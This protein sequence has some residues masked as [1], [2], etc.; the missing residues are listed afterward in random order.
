MHK[1]NQ[2]KK[3]CTKFFHVK[4]QCTKKIREKNVHKIHP[5]KKNSVQNSSPKNILHKKKI[6]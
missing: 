6:R 4:K 5:G 1:K 2:R 3:Q